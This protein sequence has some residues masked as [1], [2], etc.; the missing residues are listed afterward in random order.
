MIFILQDNA[1]ASSGSFSNFG[2]T[3]KPPSGYDYGSTK[4]KSLLAGTFKFIPTEI[5]VFYLA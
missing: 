3:Y 5:E 2:S 4:A 1:N